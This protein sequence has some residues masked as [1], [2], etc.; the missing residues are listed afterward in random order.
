M[1]IVPSLF[2]AAVSLAAFASPALAAPPVNDNYLASLPVD[3]VEFSATTDTTEATTQPDLFNPSRDGQPLGGGTTENTICKGTPFGKTVWYDLAPQAS[4][5]VEVS[6]TAVGFAPVVAVY[7][8]SQANSQITRMLDCTPTA[9]GRLQLE[10]QKG[11]SYTIQVGGAGAAGGATTLNVDYFP[12][13]DGDGEF[14]PLDKC[15]EVAGIDRF[16]GCPPELRVAPSLSF[17]RTGNGIRI[18]RLSL[19][20][21][22]KGAKVV[23][24]CTG[25]GSQTV[26]VKRTG[27][28]SLT[29]LVGKSVRGG[30]NVE[31]RVTLG[32]TG[33][34]TYRFGATGNFFKWPVRAS[35]LGPRETRC[36]KV[37]TASKLEN[38]A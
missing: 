7:E 4:G 34:G 6:A 23:A 35:G 36:I 16:G 17:D 10:V 8:W 38:C 29:K 19:E 27:R 14:D 20:R 33:N 30:G 22:P 5:A 28:V 21:V 32:R 2:A 13:T 9:G 1:R 37:G 18:T 15:P 26:R 3:K 31:V 11:R 24:R 12:D 25:C